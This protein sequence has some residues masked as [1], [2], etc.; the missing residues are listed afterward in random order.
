MNLRKS[1]KQLGKQARREVDQR[2]RTKACGTRADY[3]KLAVVK[4]DKDHARPGDAWRNE[5]EGHEWKGARGK[6]KQR[7]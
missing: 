1:M 3:N 4:V 2:V 5:S 6:M 7:K